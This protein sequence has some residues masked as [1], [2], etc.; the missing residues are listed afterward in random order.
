[1]CVWRYVLQLFREPES[2]QRWVRNLYSSPIV[3]AVPYVKL[4]EWEVFKNKLYCSSGRSGR[5][6]FP[7]V[8]PG[9]E[10]GIKIPALQV[11]PGLIIE[12]R[13]MVCTILESILK[14][15]PHL[16]IFFFNIYI[17]EKEKKTISGFTQGRTWVARFATHRTT[18]WVIVF[19]EGLN[20]DGFWYLPI[21]LWWCWH[22]LLAKRMWHR[23]LAASTDIMCLYFGADDATH[24]TNGLHMPCIFQ[25]IKDKCQI[26]VGPEML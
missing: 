14:I 16:W 15:L 5:E 20:S 7:Y 2:L 22:F 18:Y 23:L 26:L 4:L 10:G 12:A 19:I 25:R 9:G 8:E 1:M 11:N 13:I 6:H 24:S 3:R 21:I 17:H